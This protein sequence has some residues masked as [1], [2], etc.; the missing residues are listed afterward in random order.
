MGLSAYWTYLDNCSAVFAQDRLRSLV[1]D[2]F[3]LT[4]WKALMLSAYMDE[5]DTRDGIIYS[6]IYFCPFEL[7]KLA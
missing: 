2:I 6:C 5:C 7:E 1:C 4:M 3:F